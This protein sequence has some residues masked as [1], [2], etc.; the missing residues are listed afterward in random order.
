MNHALISIFRHRT[1]QLAALITVGVLAG[2]HLITEHVLTARHLGTLDHLLIFAVTT[3]WL[4]PASLAAAVLGLR[5]ARFL[6]IGVTRWQHR[7]ESAGLISIVMLE[8]L[9]IG[10]VLRPL[11]HPIFDALLSAHHHTTDP[12]HGLLLGQMLTFVAALAGLF[13]L[14]LQ[15]VRWH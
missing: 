11:T 4:L 3:L 8:L 6:G 2:Q 5:I 12:L 14:P 9:L 10:L 1:L 15:D 7:V 13:L